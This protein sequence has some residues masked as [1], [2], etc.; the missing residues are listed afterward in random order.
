MF[1]GTQC[2]SPYPTDTRS[3]HAVVSSLLKKPELNMADMANFRPVSSNLIYM[4]IFFTSYAPE[5]LNEFLATEDLLPHNQSAY[6]RR[7][8]T[9]TSMLRVLSA[10]LAAADSRQQVTL[11]G[12]LDL[13]SAFDFDTAIGY[14][15]SSIG[16]WQWSDTAPVW[17]PT[18]VTPVNLALSAVARFTGCLADVGDWMTTSRCDRTS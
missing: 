4:H 13:S 7:H 2:R 3:M 10:A 15:T 14:I 8:S 11:I 12:M 18:R 9:E 17:L 6:R 16:L 1:F 5:Q